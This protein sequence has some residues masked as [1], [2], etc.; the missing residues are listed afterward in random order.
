MTNEKYVLG[1]SIN[2]WIKEFPIIE[3]ISNC[4]EGIWIN[5]K[6]LPFRSTVQTRTISAKNGKNS[7]LRFHEDRLAVFAFWLTK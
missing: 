5:D 2:E 7:G 1:K 4:D 3:K 6:K